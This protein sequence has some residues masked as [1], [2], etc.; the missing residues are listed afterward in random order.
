MEVESELDVSTN[1][2]MVD[3]NVLFEIGR[4]VLAGLGGNGGKICVW[5]GFV[6]SIKYPL[7]SLFLFVFAGLR[8]ILIRFS[9][10]KTFSIGLRKKNDA[11]FFRKWWSDSGI[12]CFLVRRY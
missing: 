1:V 5:S 4:F 6:V 2:F 8:L 10:F 3:C 11:S 12:R 9:Q 7:M